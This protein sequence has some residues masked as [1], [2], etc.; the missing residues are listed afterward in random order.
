M[1]SLSV[2]F[3]S[4]VGLTPSFFFLSV[5]RGG[6][7]LKFHEKWRREIIIAGLRGKQEGARV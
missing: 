1:I 5:W 6:N 2:C 7:N 3:Y 4:S